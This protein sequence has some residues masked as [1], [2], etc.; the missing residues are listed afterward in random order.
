MECNEKH[1]TIASQQDGGLARRPLPSGYG[2]GRREKF[3]KTT[4][5]R[6]LLKQQ[7]RDILNK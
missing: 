6:R 7:Y 4:E 2:R 1:A 3:L 5:G